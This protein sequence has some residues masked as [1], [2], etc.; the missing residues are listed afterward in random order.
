MKRKQ[1][2]VRWLPV[3]Y[4]ITWKTGGVNKWILS[5]RACVIQFRCYWWYWTNGRA[6][7]R[8]IRTFSPFVEP[9]SY[10]FETRTRPEISGRSRKSFVS[11]LEQCDFSSLIENRGCDLLLRK[12]LLRAQQMSCMNIYIYI[13]EL[14]MSVDASDANLSALHWKWF[15]NIA[16]AFL[17]VNG[18]GNKLK[19]LT[20]ITEHKLYWRI[21]KKLQYYWTVVHLTTQN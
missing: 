5:I 17:A 6:D 19:I 15:W 14:W 3:P 8:W 10:K 16:S 9:H 1:R 4:V 12:I 11:A 20:K 13:F 18:R 7:Y 21:T 2:T